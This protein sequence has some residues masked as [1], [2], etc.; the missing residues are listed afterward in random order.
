MRVAGGDL[1]GIAAKV[2]TEP[3]GEKHALRSP[4][5]G[6]LRI[7]IVGSQSDARYSCGHI[8]VGIYRSF[9]ITPFSENTV[10]L[11]SLLL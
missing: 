5:A 11:S 9:W 6:R 2:P 8:S 7:W 3:A 4:H 10:T 1:C